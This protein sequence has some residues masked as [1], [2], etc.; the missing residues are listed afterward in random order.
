MTIRN[1]WKG[2]RRQW[3]CKY[4][5][6][7]IQSRFD[8]ASPIPTR[9]KTIDMWKK[10]KFSTS[11][12]RKWWLFDDECFGAGRPSYKTIADTFGI[13]KNLAYRICTTYKPTAGLH[14][15]YGVSR[16]GALFR[17]SRREDAT[18]KFKPQHKV[19]GGT[20]VTPTQDS[21]FFI[22]ATSPRTHS[23]DWHVFVDTEHN[24]EIS[25]ATKRIATR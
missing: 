2:T 9:A 23:T 5:K 19:S 3:R 1:L 10:G 6:S 20:T 17:P 22:A 16:W 14:G 12:S 24:P 11:Q 15:W 13:T 18:L 8:A 25:C 4:A 7:W 21:C